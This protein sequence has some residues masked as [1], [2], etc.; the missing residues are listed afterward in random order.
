V[1][2]LKKQGAKT[3][4]INQPIN[5]NVQ[6]LPIKYYQILQELPSLNVFIPHHPA[7]TD[8]SE[9]SHVRGGFPIQLLVILV[10]NEVCCKFVLI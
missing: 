2:I 5:L 3:E 7:K 10:I 1:I 6:F 4:I 9:S 8:S